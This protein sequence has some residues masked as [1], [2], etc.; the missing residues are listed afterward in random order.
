ML[1]RDGI[2]VR[3]GVVNLAAVGAANAAVVYTIPAL[4]AQLIGTKSA[5][6]RKVIMHNNAAGTTTVLIGTGVG[7]AFV[8]LLPALDSI[9]GFT[10]NYDYLNGLPEAESFANIT[11]YPVALGAG[12]SIDIQL[13]VEIR[14]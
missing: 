13:E 1:V 2:Y 4:A 3:S 5:R 10:D 7:G 12:T 11:A 8:A 9:N 6:I 14:G